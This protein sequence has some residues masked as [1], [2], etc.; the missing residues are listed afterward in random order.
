[1]ISTGKRKQY[2]IKMLKL[3][4]ILVRTPNTFWREQ[5]K[6]EENERH[7][8][9][10]QRGWK[11]EVIGFFVCSS[12]FVE[13]FLEKFFPPKSKVGKKFDVD[14]K[15]FLCF[16][17]SWRPPFFGKCGEDEK[18]FFEQTNFWSGENRC[19]DPLFR[20]AKKEDISLLHRRWW[21]WMKN[22][23]KHE[24]KIDK[25]IEARIKNRQMRH[26]F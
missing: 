18:F 25:W 21:R 16:W 7:V 4:T 1:M 19:E 6:Y 5:M 15:N 22:G 11:I 20:P 2:W 23:L 8:P 26:S 24:W 14:E 9:F 13:G 3:K 12:L 17:K 10:F